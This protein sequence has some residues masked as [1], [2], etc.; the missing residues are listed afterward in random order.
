MANQTLVYFIEFVKKTHRLKSK[1]AD[2]LMLRL[3]NKQLR[4]IGKK[5]KVSSERIRQIEK[6]SLIKLGTKSYQEKLF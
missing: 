4:F 6:E 1:E 5:Y 2:I 3:K